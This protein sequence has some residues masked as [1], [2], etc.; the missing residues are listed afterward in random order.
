M[1]LA[2]LRHLIVARDGYLVGILTYRA[3]LEETLAR[4]VDT[5]VGRAEASVEVAMVR[6]PECVSSERSLTDVAARLWRTGLGCLP[7]VEPTGSGP[8]LVGLVTET[9]L[10]RAA[11]DPFFGPS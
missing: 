4:R 11:Y 10:L 6:D 7:V 9:D 2:R 1:R 3:V 5:A 8:R